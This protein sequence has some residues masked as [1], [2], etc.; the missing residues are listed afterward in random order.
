MVAL[1]QNLPAAATAHHL[2]VQLVV[3]RTRIARS[4]R[5]ANRDSERSGLNGSFPILQT[6]RSW[7]LNR[8]PSKLV[9]HAPVA[10]PGRGA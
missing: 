4:Q 10:R 9:Q 1:A 2:V 7:H 8:H 3:A 6:Q 5:E